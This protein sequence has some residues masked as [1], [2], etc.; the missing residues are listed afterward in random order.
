[1]STESLPSK[2]LSMTGGAVLSPVGDT[3]PLDRSIS[4]PNIAGGLKLP[5]A[6]PPSPT[7]LAS[8][9]ST[10]SD[11]SRGG[12]AS[13]D[14]LGSMF[15]KDDLLSVPLASE[16]TQSLTTERS[17]R[18]A[19]PSSENVP[20]LSLSVDE[21]SLRSSSLTASLEPTPDLVLNLPTALENAPATSHTHCSP[22]TTAEMFASAEHGT[23]KKSGTPG[24]SSASGEDGT[25]MDEVFPHTPVEIMQALEG[26]SFS[27]DMLPSPPPVV[28][29][30]AAFPVESADN[31]GNVTLGHES[32]SHEESSTI[33]LPHCTVSLAS[34]SAS[35]SCDTGSELPTTVCASL[36]NTESVAGVLEPSPSRSSSSTKY[37]GCS[38]D[39]VVGPPSEPLVSEVISVETVCESPEV[40]TSGKL[41]LQSSDA[42]AEVCPDVRDVALSAAELQS[43]SSK[44]EIAHQ[45]VKMCTEL[46]LRI[47]EQELLTTEQLPHPVT[48]AAVSPD[49]A[50]CLPSADDVDITSEAPGILHSPSVTFSSDVSTDAAVQSTTSASPMELRPAFSASARPS[51]SPTCAA[52]TVTISSQPGVAKSYHSAAERRSSDSAVATSSSRILSSTDSPPLSQSAVSH[53]VMTTHKQATS[54]AVTSLTDPLPHRPPPSLAAHSAA[55]QLL[56]EKRDSSAAVMATSAVSTVERLETSAKQELSP[57]D[58]PRSKP[59]PVKKKPS[60]P[61]KEK[62]FSAFGDHHQQ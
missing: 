62:F 18:S 1:M 29:E 21:Q 33:T 24:R 48:E 38:G 37:D 5:S 44:V 51:S 7:V 31:E 34:T 12:Y 43:E 41:R 8:C 10:S 30:V 61:L 32:P 6:M 4:Q 45:P 40:N 15:S 27:F 59:P 2:A 46:P 25:G 47:H 28:T 19:S 16:E 39:L 56:S 3:E 36:Q 13:A 60:G 26:D 14:S 54:V 42:S 11:L 57:T 35:D 17:T 50:S 52:S 49:D 9:S 53:L 22:L 55:L 58:K 20:S 23:I